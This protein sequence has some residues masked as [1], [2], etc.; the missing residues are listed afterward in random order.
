MTVQYQFAN[1]AISM[2]Y[3]S[4]GLE[5]LKL[6]LLWLQA[7]ITK[8]LQ[9]TPNPDKLNPDIQCL[10]NISKLQSPNHKKA[11]ILPPVAYCL[12][13]ALPTVMELFVILK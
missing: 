12:S 2:G 11:F 4:S 8:P 10:P 7:D 6:L 9:K 3:T 13:I 5:L 1:I